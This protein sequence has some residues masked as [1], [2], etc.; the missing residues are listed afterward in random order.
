MLLLESVSLKMVSFQPI[1]KGF[2]SENSH[3]E[4]RKKMI[5]WKTLDKQQ[6]MKSLGHRQPL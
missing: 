3:V 4:T 1:F 6:K 5:L 2:N